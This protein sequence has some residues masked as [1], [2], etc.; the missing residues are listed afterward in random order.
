MS[1]KK[2]RIAQAEVSAGMR[3]ALWDHHLLEG[4]DFR[5]SGET[6]FVTPR[7]AGTLGDVK[8]GERKPQKPVLVGSFVMGLTS[9]FGKEET[10]T[11]DEIR[12]DLIK[13]FPEG[14]TILVQLGWYRGSRENSV[15][16]VIENSGMGLSEEDFME[17]LNNFVRTLVEKYRQ[18]EIWVDYYRGSETVSN[19]RF[20]WE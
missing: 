16:V 7:E 9:G 3:H 6:I 2:H 13:T 15:R 4:I 1:D 14:G 19:L 5:P 20:W 10:F 18:K 12:E 17:K 11:P 8:Q